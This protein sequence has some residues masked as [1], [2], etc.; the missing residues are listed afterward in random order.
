MSRA[1]RQWVKEHQDQAWSLARYLLSDAGE[2]EDATHADRVRH[3]QPVDDGQHGDWKT[4]ARQEIAA[5]R[6]QMS[7][8]RSDVTSVIQGVI[9]LDPGVTDVAQAALLVALASWLVFGVLLWGR[10]RFGW[11]GRTALRWTLVGFAVLALAYFGSKL[12]LEALLG[13]QWG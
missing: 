4:Q 10:Y 13:R 1:Y 12:V 8:S 2:A 6:T 7:P 5:C 11:R 9:D 3:A